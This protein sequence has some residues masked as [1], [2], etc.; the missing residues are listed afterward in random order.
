[1]SQEVIIFSYIAIILISAFTIL[2]SVMRILIKDSQVHIEAKFKNNINGFNHLQDQRDK[3]FEK[4]MK[5][6][7]KDRARIEHCVNLIEKLSNR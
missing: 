1:M 7:S 3:E 2:I 5:N 4:T 6:A